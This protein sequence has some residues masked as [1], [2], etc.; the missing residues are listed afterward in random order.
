MKKYFDIKSLPKE[1]K[2]TIAFIC[3]NVLQKGITFISLPIFTRIMS[4]DQMGEVTLYLSWMEIL[5]VFLTL[6]LPYGSFSKAM[7]DFEKK[8][9]AYLSSAEGVCVVL[10]SSF[11]LL[12]VPFGKS[13]SRIMQLPLI[14]LITMAIEILATAGITFWSG[15][16]RFEYKY[17]E[18]VAVTL[19]VSFLSPILQ[20]FMIINCENKGTAKIFGNAIVVV[21]FG[22]TL[23]L[24]GLIKGRSFFN[25]DFW[26][27][28]L[29]FNFPLV[30]YYLSQIIF[31]TSDRIMINNLCGSQK[32]GIYGVVYNLATALVFVLNSINNAYTP[33]IYQRIK[34]DKMEKN[35]ELSVIIALFLSFLILMIILFAPEIIWIIG[36]ANYVEAK[37][38][39]PP[40]SL[41]IILTFYSQMF[42]AYEFYFEKKTFL[43]L[44][45]I[46]P[47]FTNI[48]LNYIFIP[49]YGYL[50][51]GYTTF[52]SYIL[53][54][55]INYYASRRII[56]EKKLKT[57]GFNMLHL[58]MILFASVIVSFV[59]M[60]LYS[61]FF[62][63]LGLFACFIILCLIWK[64]RINNLLLFIKENVTF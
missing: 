53:L 34:D 64:K 24:F 32:A 36:G 8:R 52:I 29:N 54:M 38:I 16:K 9:D 59:F 22:M 47:A 25:Y 63:R 30:P 28:A 2:V 57:N 49:K 27:Y 15:K 33:W 50:A 43:I 44:S 51:A 42:A 48:V 23:F 46:C 10:T 21:L 4:T 7:V 55:L 31:N 19:G 61:Y 14:L 20:Y 1:L 12:L 11:L 56:K 13:I 40:V 5:T 45:A 60:L 37:W 41:T 6:Q 39:I 3:C 17:I 62:A 26:K 18:V 58:L 35:K